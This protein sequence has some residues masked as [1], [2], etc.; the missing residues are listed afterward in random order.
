MAV[1]ESSKK[2]QLNQRTGDIMQPYTIK[3]KIFQTGHIKY[4]I[5]YPKYPVNQGLTIKNIENFIQNFIVWSV[6]YQSLIIVYP[7]EVLIQNSLLVIPLNFCTEFYWWKCYLP[8]TQHGLSQWGAESTLSFR[9]GR[10]P[11]KR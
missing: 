3:S 9:F 1:L 10:N 2:T 5:Q 11:H 8:V 7:N 4:H 6:T